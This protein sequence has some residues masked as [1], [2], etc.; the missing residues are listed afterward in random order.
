MSSRQAL[1]TARWPLL[2]QVSQ[3]YGCL[4]VLSVLIAELPP[5]NF[6]AQG[7][8]SMQ[9]WAMPSTVAEQCHEAV[10]FFWIR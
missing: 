10:H 8:V 4:Q 3:K 2:W 7:K 6:I 5:A 1:R 9:S